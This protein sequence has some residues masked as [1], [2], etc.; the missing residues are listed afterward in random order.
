[1]GKTLS[2]P[3]F[4][5]PTFCS[6]EGCFQT[7]P[8]TKRDCCWTTQLQ[9]AAPFLPA[10][11]LNPFSLSPQDPL[12][13]IWTP[14]SMAGCEAQ[15]L[16]MWAPLLGIGMILQSSSGPGRPGYQTHSQTLDSGGD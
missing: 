8:F 6:L 10:S 12:G 5:C 2:P 16:P 15:V 1:M 9:A 14:W 13:G 4:L 3:M 11:S 7:D